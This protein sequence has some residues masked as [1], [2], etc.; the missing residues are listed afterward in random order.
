MSNVIPPAPPA[1]IR[2]LA[3]STSSSAPVEVPVM[4][5]VLFGDDITAVEALV[6]NREIP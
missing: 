4:E 6:G 3:A 1:D 5:T 2:E